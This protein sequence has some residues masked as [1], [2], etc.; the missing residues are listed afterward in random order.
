MNTRI[1][2][3]S[4]QTRL[5][6][7]LPA[8]WAQAV[9]TSPTPTE[10]DRSPA[11]LF[12]ELYRVLRD[13][14]T[15]WLLTTDTQLPSELTCHGWM[16]RTVR[17]LTP[18]RVDPAG[19]VRLHLLVKQPR[20]FYNARAA[21]LYC[22]PRTHAAVALA[23]NRRRF[24]GWSPDQRRELVRLCILAGS[25][26]AACGACGAPYTRGPHTRATCAHHNPAGRCLVLDPFYKP[27]S[28]THE[29]TERYGRA[30]LGIITG[31][32]R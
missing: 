15:L 6:A 7:E 10:L 20:Y 4:N 27:A 9:I 2:T 17:W 3:A 12:D 29:I 24:C 11:A 25:S 22:A 1:E 30:F 5:L 16:R 32:H 26:R 14:G 31:A 19:R 8:R 28:R 13:D 18:L 23:A 21:E